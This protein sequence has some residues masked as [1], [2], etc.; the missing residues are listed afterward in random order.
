MKYTCVGCG[1]NKDASE[2]SEEP[3]LPGICKECDS[4]F[5]EPEDNHT[6]KINEI[7][8]EQRDEQRK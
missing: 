7:K 1:L 8:G 5:E 6:V 2:F 3:N 4:L